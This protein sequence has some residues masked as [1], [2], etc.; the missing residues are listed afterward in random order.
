MKRDQKSTA[1]SSK[2][3]DNT[4]CEFIYMCPVTLKCKINGLYTRMG[5]MNCV[6]RDWFKG[7]KNAIH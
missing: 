1:K 6:C 7:V 5:T 2:K 4:K 3:L